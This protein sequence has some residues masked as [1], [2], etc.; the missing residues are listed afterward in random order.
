MPP[1]CISEDDLRE[2]LKI[3]KDA[4]EELKKNGE[5]MTSG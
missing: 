1:L 3:F 5:K 4:M 2:G